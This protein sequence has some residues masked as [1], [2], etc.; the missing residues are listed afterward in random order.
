MRRNGLLS[1]VGRRTIAVVELAFILLF[2]V[3]KFAEHEHHELIEEHRDDQRDE[4][5]EEYELE[6]QAAA[7]KRC[8]HWRHWSAPSYG[9]DRGSKTTA[10]P[11][12]LHRLG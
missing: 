8:C 1:A 2:R 10:Q 7:F 4:S 5:G 3:C 11:A 9:V 6:D 12:K